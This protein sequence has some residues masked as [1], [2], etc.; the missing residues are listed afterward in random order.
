MLSDPSIRIIP[1]SR[2]PAPEGLPGT[3]SAVVRGDVDV[4]CVLPR[5]W[6]TGSDPSGELVLSRREPEDPA[7]AR[8][9]LLEWL[10]ANRDP[11]VIIGAEG[12][13]RN[14]GWILATDH[15]RLFGGARG[16]RQDDGE[17][18]LFPS[19]ESLYNAQ[20]GKYTLR[21]L[22]ETGCDAVMI[23]RA[24]G[25]AVLLVRVSEWGRSNESAA[26]LALLMDGL[27]RSMS[28]RRR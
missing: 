11:V 8:D 27:R 23:G 15:V 16:E 22:Q 17:G 19:L 25:R 18:P 2:E 6:K 20:L 26:P 21:M 13:G 24:G 7:K 12:V 9:S 3:A 28:D 4:F 14:A 10:R 5:D 1:V